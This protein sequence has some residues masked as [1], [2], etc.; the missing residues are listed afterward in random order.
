MALGIVGFLQAI[1]R[2][3][4]IRRRDGE[5]RWGVFRDIEISNRY[6]ESFL[7]VSWA[8]HPRQHQRSTR[9]DRAVVEA[10]HNYVRGEPVVRHLLYV[11]TK[12]AKDK[13]PM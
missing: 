2:Y 13:P 9:A 11:A 10:V 6:L 4:R 12:V 1:H 8:E 3:E 5:Y 7:V